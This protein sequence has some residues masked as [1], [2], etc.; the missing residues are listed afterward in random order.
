MPSGFDLSEETPPGAGSDGK[1]RSVG[2][3]GITDGDGDGAAVVAGDFDAAA[4][5]GGA[6]TNQ[7]SRVACCSPLVTQSWNHAGSGPFPRRAIPTTHSGGIPARPHAWH[8]AASTS[9]VGGRSRFP[10]W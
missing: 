9:T 6:V 3:L 1:N 2:V 10:P 8:H 5:V 4:A 7:R